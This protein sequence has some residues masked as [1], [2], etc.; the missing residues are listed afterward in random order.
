MLGKCW[1]L[2]VVVSVYAHHVDAL[3]CLN[4]DA[5]SHPKFCLHV[6]QCYTGEQC[7]METYVDMD[8]D[9]VYK[10]GCME[11][12]TCSVQTNTTVGGNQFASCHKCCDDEDLCN[13]AGCGSTGYPVHRGPICYSCENQLE[14]SQCHHITH[15]EPTEV[16]YDEVNEMFDTDRLVTSG[17]KSQHHCPTI[18]VDPLIGKRTSH[19]CSDCCQ[20]DLCN[21]QCENNNV[22]QCVDDDDDCPLLMANLNICATPGVASQLCKKSCGYCSDTNC[23]DTRVDC[24]TIN[25]T[26]NICPSESVAKSFGCFQYCGF[27][28][29][30]SSPTMAPYTHTTPTFPTTTTTLPPTT[31][32]TMPPTTTTTM[33]PTTTTTMPPT[34][35]TTMPTTTTRLPPTT[36]LQ[37]TT[38]STQSMLTL[39]TGPVNFTSGPLFVGDIV[40]PGPDWVWGDQNGNGTG[41]VVNNTRHGWVTVYWNNTKHEDVYRYGNKSL[42]DVQL[43]KSGHVIT[44]QPTTTVN[45][46]YVFQ[47][48][49]KVLRGPDWNYG[50][51]DG[52]GMGVVTDILTPGWV[53]VKWNITNYSNL[54]RNGQDGFHDIIKILPLTTNPPPPSTTAPPTAGPVLAQDMYVGAIVQRGKDWMYGTQDGN[55]HGVVLTHDKANGWVKVRWTSGYVNNYRIGADNSYDIQFA[56]NTYNPYS[57]MSP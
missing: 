46:L 55:G 42:Y 35:T 16:C 54:Y 27:C 31:T 53:G 17:C 24:K 36:T 33:P 38:Q 37:P 5:I 26:V 18:G 39:P 19:V 1:L 22:N 48:G 20:G 21:K 28:T 15:C 50:I 41:V 8:G 29:K 14:G 6:T 13:V 4:C 11:P 25:N 51:Q 43:V 40:M 30:V 52:N 32:T 23:V 44:P 7:G 34:T 2:F 12:K 45:P 56:P 3:M 49:D 10:L 47:V 57:T 9:L